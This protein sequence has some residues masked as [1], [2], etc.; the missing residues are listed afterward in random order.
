VKGIRAEENEATGA[1]YT[2]YARWCFST[3]SRSGM[4]GEEQLH[5]AHYCV[6]IAQ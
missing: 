6:H 4:N 5:Y 3:Q 2:V 1:Q